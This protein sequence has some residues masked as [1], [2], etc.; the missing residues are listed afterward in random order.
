MSYEGELFEKIR[1][2]VISGKY[3]IR[4]HAVCHMIEEGFNEE[5]V[6]EA[7]AG[8]AKI[9]ENYPDDCRCLILGVFY[10]AKNTTSALHVVCDYSKPDLVDIVTAYIPQKPWWVSPSKR[11]MIL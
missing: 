11:G 3:R 7:I 8:K 2:L 1:R 5:N 9:I 4:I 10:L 6:K